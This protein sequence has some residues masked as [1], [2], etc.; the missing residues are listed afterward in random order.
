MWRLALFRLNVPAIIFLRPHALRFHSGKQHN[1]KC[2]EAFSLY[3]DC[4]D[5]IPTKDRFAE[6]KI[7]LREKETSSSCS[8]KSGSPTCGVS[9]LPVPRS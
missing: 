1:G 9:T 8:L 6:K 2:A 4:C 5:D 7:L 3:A